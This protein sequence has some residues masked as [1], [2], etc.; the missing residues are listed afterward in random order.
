[1]AKTHGK[2]DRAGESKP[3]AASV[4]LTDAQLVMLSRAAQ[5]EDGWLPCPRAS[6][7][8]PDRRSRNPSSTKA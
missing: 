1:M 7:A 3:K 5:R 8:T 4:K 6:R 2:S